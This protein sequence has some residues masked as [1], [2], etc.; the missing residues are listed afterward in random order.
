MITCLTCRLGPLLVGMGSRPNTIT[1]LPMLCL[2]Y[3]LMHVRANDHYLRLLININNI[4]IMVEQ[5]Q[6]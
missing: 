1:K 3:F 2:L 4:E 5:N 6:S